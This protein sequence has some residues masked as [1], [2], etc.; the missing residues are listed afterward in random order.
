[1][2]IN[3]F[4]LSFYQDKN[5]WKHKLLA[6]DV[7]KTGTDRVID[8]VI[9]KNHFVPIK[10][11]HTFSGNH[12]CIYV[13]RSCLNSYISQNVLIKHKQ[14]CEEQDITN[15]RT[16]N[17]SHLHWKKHFLKNLLYFSIIADFDADNE[18]GKSSIGNKTTNI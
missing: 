13:C 9:Y 11:L 4:E 15:I 6:L 17:V 7:S 2:T 16:S 10:K 14:Q 12:N 5:K 18:I 1:M 3:L 8:L